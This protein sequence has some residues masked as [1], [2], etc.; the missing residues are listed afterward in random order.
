VPNLP[1]WKPH[2]EKFLILLPHRIPNFPNPPSKIQNLP[3]PPPVTRHSGCAAIPLPANPV[4]LSKIHSKSKIR[5]NVTRQQ[6]FRF[7]LNLE[8]SLVSKS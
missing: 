4:L 7:L 5:L 6:T 1:H 2:F 3:H 8:N